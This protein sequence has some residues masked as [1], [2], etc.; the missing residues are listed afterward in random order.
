MKNITNEIQKCPSDGKHI[1][2]KILCMNK[3]EWTDVE[4]IPGPRSDC[5]RFLTFVQDLKSKE[6]IVDNPKSKIQ[7]IEHKPDHWWLIYV[8]EGKTC[9]P[10]LQYTTA[11]PE[12]LALLSSTT[13][14]KGVMSTLATMALSQQDK[15]IKLLNK[16]DID[17]KDVKTVINVANRVAELYPQDHT[18]LIHKMLQVG[19]QA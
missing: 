11:P 9:F 1:E 4:I 18:E 12:L 19:Q 6:N 15:L 8:Q 7:V 17:E 2:W 10:H 16:H 3:A 13:D 14:W 5:E